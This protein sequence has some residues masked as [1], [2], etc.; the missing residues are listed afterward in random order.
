MAVIASASCA[1]L[2][3]AGVSDRDLEDVAAYMG[4]CNENP[5]HYEQDAWKAALRHERQ[6]IIQIIHEQ[7]M[8]DLTVSHIEVAL[9]ERYKGLI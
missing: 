1:R 4:W 7:A 3:R 6:R 5:H 9:R 8:N 2:W